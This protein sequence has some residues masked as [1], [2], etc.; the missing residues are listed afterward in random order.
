M[1]ESI[2]EI[3]IVNYITFLFEVKN[4]SQ[5]DYLVYGHGYYKRKHT[6]SFF[7]PKG[8]TLFD[9]KQDYYYEYVSDYRFGQLKQLQEALTSHFYLQEVL[10]T[11][12]GKRYHPYFYAKPSGIYGPY[13][14]DAEGASANGSISLGFVSFDFSV[15]FFITK[16]HNVGLHFSNNVTYGFRGFFTSTS[17]SLDFHDMYDNDTL[18]SDNFKYDEEEF[19]DSFIGNSSG[20]GADLIGVGFS[21]SKSADKMYN[22]LSRGVRT[23]SISLMKPSISNLTIASKSEGYTRLIYFK[24]N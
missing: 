4:G 11:V 9:I 12:E 10:I 2:L 8:I 22:T 18:Y 7:Y 5:L 16:Y 3:R 20:V 6:T 19:V 24:T 23:N 15:G 13:I 14:P 17:V 21:Q 1:E